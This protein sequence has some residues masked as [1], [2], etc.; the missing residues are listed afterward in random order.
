MVISPW[1]SQNSTRCRALLLRRFTVISVN[2]DE[3]TRPDDD[4]DAL[5][6]DDDAEEDDERGD[7]ESDEEL[8]MGGEV[9][10]D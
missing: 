3:G 4:R 7:I 5:D 6:D 8:L 1:K 10:E 2:D 9:D